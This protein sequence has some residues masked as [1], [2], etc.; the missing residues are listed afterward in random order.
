[1][2][3]RALDGS[4]EFAAAA[5]D[6]FCLIL[7]AVAGDIALVQGASAVVIGGGLGL[8]LADYL[9]RS[10]FCDRFVAKGRFERHLANITVK[11]IT[12]QQPGL[13]GAAAAFARD[14]SESAAAQALAQA[15]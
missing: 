6:R 5:L 1:M 9:P 10:S 12:H 3:T 15:H 13:Y 2:W 14:A 8:K 11:L 7:G 4:D